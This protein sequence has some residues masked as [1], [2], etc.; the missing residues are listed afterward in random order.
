MRM[1]FEFSIS[2]LPKGYRLGV[3]SIIKEMLRQGSEVYY[4]QM[5]EVNKRAMKPFAHASYIQ[6]IKVKQDEI[7][8]DKLVLTISSPF[9]EFIMHLMNGS[10][11]NTLYTYHGYEFELKHK[12]LLPNP[13]EL[14]TIVTFKTL[15]PL[16]LEDRNK[17]P[18]LVNDRSFEKELNYYAHLLVKKVYDRNLYDPIQILRSS[19]KKVVLQENLHQSQ[20]TPIFI[21]ANHGLLQLKGHPE[22]LKVLY[23]GGVGKRRSLGLG[24]LDIEEVTYT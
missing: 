7:A 11:R 15:S 19:M 12:R 23:E 9:Y 18:L 20:K 2:S 21:T 10:Q 16:H 14:S 24:L 22:D 4:K 13:P 3:L 6:N 5:F 17:K 1:Q 8:G